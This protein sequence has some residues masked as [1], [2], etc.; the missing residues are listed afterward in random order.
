LSYKKVAAIA[1]MHRHAAG[2]RSQGAG[3]R[4]GSRRICRPGG[5]RRRSCCRASR[6]PPGKQ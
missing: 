6:E 2:S 4:N 5:G 1:A 3:R